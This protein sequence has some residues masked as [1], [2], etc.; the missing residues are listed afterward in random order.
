MYWLYIMLPLHSP[1]QATPTKMKEAK[2]SPVLRLQGPLS[3]LSQP[4]LMF[5]IEYTHTTLLG[6]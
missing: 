4:F 3:L 5:Y 1:K 6:Y 2:L